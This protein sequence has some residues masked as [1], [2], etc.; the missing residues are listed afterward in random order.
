MAADNEHGQ[1]GIFIT[2]NDTITYYN[3]YI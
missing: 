1:K 3:V 2:F